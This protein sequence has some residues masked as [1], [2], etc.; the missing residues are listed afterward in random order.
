MG[1]LWPRSR[2]VWD[3]DGNRTFVLQEGSFEAQM[4]LGWEFLVGGWRGFVSGADARLRNGAFFSGFSVGVPLINCGVCGTCTRQGARKKG[5][6]HSGSMKARNP[7]G[8]AHASPGGELG[9]YEPKLPTLERST[10]LRHPRQTSRNRTAL[11]RRMLTGSSPFPVPQN[12]QWGLRLRVGAWRTPRPDESI[13]RAV[14]RVNPPD[15]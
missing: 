15:S 7:I 10:P 4:G 14:N 12:W 2:G 5:P 3:G 11:G 13:A 8:Q 1:D 9:P 6:S